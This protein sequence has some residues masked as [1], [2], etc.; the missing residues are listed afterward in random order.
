ML[1]FRI[2]NERCSGC[3][4]LE[5]FSK[6]FLQCECPADLRMDRFESFDTSSLQSEIE[7][8]KNELESSRFDTQ[9]MFDEEE[10]HKKSMTDEIETLKNELKSR[11]EQVATLIARRD[12]LEAMLVS[13]RDDA[14]EQ[15]ILK[16]QMKADRD[17]MHVKNGI[18]EKHY[19]NEILKKEECIEAWKLADEKK[20]A[21]MSHLKNL[22]EDLERRVDQLRET[23]EQ[24]LKESMRMKHL[25]YDNDCLSIENS[26]LKHE[27]EKLTEEND[28]IR[29]GD[30]ETEYERLKWKNMDLQSF[31]EATSKDNTVLKKTNEKL[32]SRI[33]KEEKQRKKEFVA[34]KT[35]LEATI[36]TLKTEKKQMQVEVNKKNDEFHDMKIELASL[37]SQHSNLEVLFEKTM[38]RNR[39][40]DDE[41]IKL[42][43]IVEQL[44]GDE[45]LLKNEMTLRNDALLDEISILKRAAIEGQN[46]VMAWIQ[47]ERMQTELLVQSQTNSI[48]YLEQIKLLS[49]QLAEQK[50]STVKQIETAVAAAI[51][52]NTVN[53]EAIMVLVRQVA[54]E[55]ARI[56]MLAQ[57]VVFAQNNEIQMLREEVLTMEKKYSEQVAIQ[58]TV[59]IQKTAELT[60]LVFRSPNG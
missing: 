52:E 56:S 16:D 4:T 24:L 36:E 23:N 14:I 60:I 39:E 20:N 44:S 30:M 17:D 31:L 9:K 8:L 11:D 34:M 18:L 26:D 58:K 1:F 59:R 27:L 51:L 57:Q 46:T 53:N 3:I 32:E 54:A 42:G 25:V 33:E 29:R 47:K 21:E 19:R 5:K 6:D 2:S 13:A 15:M 45:I 55:N 37:K 41:V 22:N 35:E 49:A 48:E 50:A 40:L 28:R 7:K 12:K 43:E 38:K 10:L